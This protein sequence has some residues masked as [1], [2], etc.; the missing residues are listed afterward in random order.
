MKFINFKVGDQIRLGLKTEKGVI[1][2]EQSATALSFELPTKIE[3][4]IAGGEKVLRQLDELT[5]Q[6]FTPFQKKIWYMLHVSLSQKKLF[7]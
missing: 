6:K 4:V 7:V 3:Q 2:V 5:K 1:D